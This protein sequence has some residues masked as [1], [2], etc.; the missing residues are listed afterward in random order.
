MLDGGLEYD[1]LGMEDGRG[2]VMVQWWWRMGE[3][4]HNGETGGDDAYAGL[5]GGPDE[6]ACETVG[7]VEMS[8]KDQFDDADDGYGA[9]AG[10]GKR[11]SAKLLQ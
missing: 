3:L 1:V 8:R 4:T 5:D 9:N 7:G 11:R 2:L 6:D 10:G